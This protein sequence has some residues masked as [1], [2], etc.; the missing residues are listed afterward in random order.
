M[1]G[2]YAWPPGIDRSMERAFNTLWRQLKSSGALAAQRQ[3]EASGAH[4]VAQQLENSAVESVRKYLESTQHQRLAFE[5]LEAQFRSPVADAIRALDAQ[6][7]SFLSHLERTIAPLPDV[8]RWQDFISGEYFKLHNVAA[9]FESIS[10]AVEK[11]TL[12]WSSELP[13]FL[14]LD[15]EESLTEPAARTPAQHLRRT[16]PA[17]A[18]V[19]LESVDF[20]P[21]RVLDHIYRAPKLIHQ[22]TPRQFEQLVAEI[23]EELGFQGVELTPRSGD[24][25]RDVVASKHVNGVPI[26]FAFECKKQ[27]P[28]R[29]VG[30]GVARALLGTLN[31]STTRANV[32]V[33]VTT[34]TFTR[35]AQNFFLTEA[36][37]K[38]RDFRGV[39]EWLEEIERLRRGA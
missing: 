1:N 33:L 24:K 31:Q 39:V 20:L 3:L 18:L 6:H 34:S 4:L 16:V 27:K 22:L 38:G 25:G 32:G 17:D 8:S 13:E 19:R 30:V 7:A 35:G 21:L 14:E 12:L 28:Q 36:Q 26:L 10:R 2:K 5:V 29:K 37:V 11:A 23:L 15:S 9:A